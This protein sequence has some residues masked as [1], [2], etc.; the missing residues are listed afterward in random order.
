MNPQPDKLPTPDGVSAAQPADVSAAMPGPES[1]PPRPEHDFTLDPKHSKPKRE[2]WHVAISTIML[3]LLAPVIALSIAAF[4]FQSYQVDG[5]SMETTL[6]N[7]DRLIVFKVP[8]TLA[9]ITHNDY[10]PKRGDIIVFNQVGLY[11][12][13]GGTEKQLIKRVVGLPGER[14]VIK[15]GTLTVFNEAYPKGYNPDTSTGYS[16]SSATTPGTSDVTVGEGEVFVLGDNRGNSTDSRAFG[17][18]RLDYVVGKLII[19][20]IPLSK[21][22]R[23]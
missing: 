15:D 5:A 17:P 14:V 8:R 18:V 3:F 20:L 10:I 13:S 11:D 23:F 2:G 6:Q 22:E 12:T 1:A 16:T 9:R 7:R 4:A 21:V 19:R